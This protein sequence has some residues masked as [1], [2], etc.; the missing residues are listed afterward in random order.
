MQLAMA[1]LLLCLGQAA[2]ALGLGQARA[3]S[4]LQ[5]PL[6]LRIDLISRSE[7]ELATVTAGMASAADFRVMGITS[8]AIGIPMEFTIER[9]LE[10]PHIRVRSREPMTEP[11]L[12][13]VIEVVWASGRMVRQYTVFLD[14]PTFDS[15]APLPSVTPDAP[16]TPETAS[17]PSTA[18]VPEPASAPPVLESGPPF[19]PGTEP[20]EAQAPAELAESPPPAVADPEPSGPVDETPPDPP[21]EVLADATPEAAA[22]A[23]EPEAPAVRTAL[24]DPGSPSPGE[25]QV[26]R[27][28]TLWGLSTRW[29]REHGV[30]VNQ[31]MLAVQ[32][33]NPDAFNDGNINS[34][35]AGA[36]LRVPDAPEHFTYDQRQ[37][38]LEVLRQEQIYRNRWDIPTNPADLPTVADLA[39]QPVR[40]EAPVEATVDSAPEEADEGRLE[41]VPP[42]ESAA[43]D[44]DAPAQGATGDEGSA[45][46]AVVAEL[47]RAEEELANARQEN[48]YLNER[49]QELEEELDRARAQVEDSGLAQMEDN[50]REQRESGEEQPLAVVPEDMPESWLAQY[51]WWLVGVLVLLVVGLVWWLRSRAD[52]SEYFDRQNLS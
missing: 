5:Q 18:N 16:A 10:D 33:R 41:L 1:G 27:G 3:Q 2:Y 23:P 17:T 19:D 6:D 21:G 47:A 34:L 22:S 26:A 44:A 4:Y 30:D 51:V 52:D 13:L 11:V 32:Q 36:L 29:A 40:D 7:A 49:I 8:G 28:E 43:A 9:N 35:K 38:M 48:S 12:Q 31:M 46:E 20:V 37:A 39:Q 45:G 42:S 15:A 25:H 24:P 14:P 50:L